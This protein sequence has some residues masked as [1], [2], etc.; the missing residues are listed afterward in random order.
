MS[1]SSTTELH[2]LLAAKFGEETADKLISFVEQETKV[3]VE[4]KFQRLVTREDLAIQVTKLELRLSKMTLDY[5]KLMLLGWGVLL[6]LLIA[7]HVK[8]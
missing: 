7:L 4:R 3:E 5:M 1:A 2:D 6:L 8:K